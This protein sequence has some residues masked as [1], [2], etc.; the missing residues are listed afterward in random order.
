MADG[1]EGGVGGEMGG[2][3]NAECVGIRD[4]DS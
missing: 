3:R 2:G 1:G 4:R